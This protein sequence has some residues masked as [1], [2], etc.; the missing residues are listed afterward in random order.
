MFGC[1]TGTSDQQ[2]INLFMISSAD[3]E[4][5]ASPCILFHKFIHAMLDVAAPMPIARSNFIRLFTLAKHYT[6][7][8]M[9]HDTINTLHANTIFRPSTT[10][11]AQTFASHY[12]PL[13]DAYALPL[14]NGNVDC[15]RVLHTQT[16]HQLYT[17]HAPERK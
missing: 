4:Y 1:V 10:Q 7:W 11:F 5:A 8:I 14:S 13:A 6:N 15:I 16:H 12:R 2:I 17:Q 3:D 9:I